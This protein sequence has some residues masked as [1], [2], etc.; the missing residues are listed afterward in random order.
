MTPPS[1]MAYSIIGGA[2]FVALAVPVMIGFADAWFVPLVIAA[3]LAPYAVYD[4]RLRRREGPDA[5]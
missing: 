4:R 1:W 5:P 3:L 2:L